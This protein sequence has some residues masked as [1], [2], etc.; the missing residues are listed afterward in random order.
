ML[1]RTSLSCSVPSTSTGTF[2]D[3]EAPSS[4]VGLGSVVFGPSTASSTLISVSVL[5]PELL[6][7][8][9]PPPPA[10][11]PPLTPMVPSPEP[12]EL[13]LHVRSPCSTGLSVSS[14]ELPDW[15]L[16]LLLPLL[17]LI[18]LLLLLLLSVVEAVVVEDPLRG[19]VEEEEDERSELL[20]EADRGRSRGLGKVT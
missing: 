20:G 13:L 9:P 2:E 1:P 7:P 18:P 17:L 8:P 19:C 15:L 14:R 11:P 3:E 10:P 12:P 16:G 6:P 4:A 5:S